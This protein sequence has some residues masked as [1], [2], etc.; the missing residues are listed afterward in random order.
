V[1]SLSIER[2]LSPASDIRPNVPVYKSLSCL[3]WQ[4]YAHFFCF[5]C[6]AIRISLCS[7][8]GCLNGITWTRKP[9]WI[10]SYIYTKYRSLKCR[11][12]AWFFGFSCLLALVYPLTKYIPSRVFIGRLLGY[13]CISFSNRHHTPLNTPSHPNLLLR[14]QFLASIFPF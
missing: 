12:G 10:S 11:N 2:S 3:A 7:G 13:A 9:C 6:A 5:V 14:Q 4:L 1:P 8:F